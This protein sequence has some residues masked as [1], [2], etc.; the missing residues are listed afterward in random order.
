MKIRFPIGDWSDDGHGHCEYFYC[1]AAGTLDDIRE[2]HFACKKKYGF[3]IGDICQEY[4][5]TRIDESIVEKIEAAGLCESIDLEERME[6]ETI[7]K[8]W[9]ELLNSIDENLKLVPESLAY[10]DINFYGYDNK[11]RHL[12][13]PG[14]GVFED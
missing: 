4:E 5:E 13:T 9:I 11:K 7:F 1:S 6:A 14:Y 2:A 3:D 12:S 8:I 10:E